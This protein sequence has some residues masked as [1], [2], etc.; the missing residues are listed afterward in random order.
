MS[1]L[2]LLLG[3]GPCP[4]LEAGLAFLQLGS[5]PGPP[6][7]VP[8]PHSALSQMLLG[9]RLGFS[10]GDAREQAG[11]LTWHRQVLTGIEVA[12]GAPGQTASLGGS[13]WA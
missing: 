7:R 9:L 4:A 2:R 6:A 12:P 13:P 10:F 1:R 8:T 3:W 5:C 11:I